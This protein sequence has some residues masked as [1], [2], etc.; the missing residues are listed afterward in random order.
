MAPPAPV[1]ELSGDRVI[2]DVKFLEGLKVHLDF[3]PG[4]MDCVLRKGASHVPFGREVERSD[5]PVGLLLLE[6]DSHLTADMIRQ[7]DILLCS[8]D[9]HLD[10]SVGDLLSGTETKLVYSIEYSLETRLQIAWLDRERS[11]LRKIYS[12][13]W[14]LGQERRRRRSFRR[15]HGLQAN[16]YPAHRA[17]APLNPSPMLYLDTRM[18]PGMFASNEEMEERI[19]RLKRGAPLRLIHSGRLEP[20]KG[21]QDLVPVAKRLV[22]AGVDFTLERNPISLDRNRRR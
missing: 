20:M 18:K 13:L 4:E 11:L 8:G 16:G 17:Y 6:P 19:A 5:L 12:G 14:T 3:W 7:Y 10:L 15:S 2:L 22:R 21:A 9:S 1:V